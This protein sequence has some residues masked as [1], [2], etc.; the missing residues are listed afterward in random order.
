MSTGNRADSQAHRTLMALH[1]AGCGDALSRTHA[2]R[3]AAR[4]CVTKEQ[5]KNVLADLAVRGYIETV[6]RITDAG[7][8]RIRGLS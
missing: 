6:V 5:S 2:S 4:T 3:V 1:D 8:A 7:M